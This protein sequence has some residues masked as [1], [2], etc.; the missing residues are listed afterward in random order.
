L[1]NDRIEGGPAHGSGAGSGPIGATTTAGRRSH[2]GHWHLGSDLKMA[3]SMANTKSG[4]PITAETT[5]PAI[6]SL[7][8]G[9]GVDVDVDVGCVS[10]PPIL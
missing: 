6:S 10:P 5:I 3:Q 4:K 9:G 8:S 1:G 7:D 2:G